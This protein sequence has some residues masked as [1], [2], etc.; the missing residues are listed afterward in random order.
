[1]SAI[2]THQITGETRIVPTGF[3][4][5]T[6]FF[7]FFP[8]LFRGDVLWAI[9]IFFSALLTWGFSSLLWPFF[10][11]GLHIKHL[12]GKGFRFGPGG[13]AAASVQQHVHVNVGN[14]S[15]TYVIPEATV[16]Q[17]PLPPVGSV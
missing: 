9:V 10:Y 5:T 2:L 4:W 11:N 13:A 14:M 3:S 8:A 15:G 16:P 6:L 12:L 7:S 17:S 1:M